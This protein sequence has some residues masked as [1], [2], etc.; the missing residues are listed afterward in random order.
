MPSNTTAGWSDIRPSVLE[1][2]KKSSIGESAR[3]KVN[4]LV[5]FVKQSKT[6]V[7]FASICE[8]S[9]HFRSRSRPWGICVTAGSIF[10]MKKNEQCSMRVESERILDG[11]RQDICETVRNN[12]EAVSRCIENDL[13]LTCEQCNTRITLV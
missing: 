8:V 11:E 12:R 3:M 7:K 2:S 5:I 13:D 9:L 10:S 4:C 6:S 1:P